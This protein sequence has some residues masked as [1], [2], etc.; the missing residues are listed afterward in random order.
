M[1]AHYTS[2]RDIMKVVRSLFLDE[3]RAEF[4]TLK[5]DRSTRRKSRL[6]EFH[7]KLRSL[8]FLDPACGCGNFLV[9]TYRELRRLELDLLRELHGGQQFTEV[10]NAIKVDVDQFYGIE[11]SEWPV[12][13]AEMALWLMDHQMN[14]EVA[15]AFGQTFRRL[16]LKNT[17]HIVQG[18]ALRIDWN[19]FLPKEQ[20]SYILGNPPFVGKQYA[21]AEQKQDMELVCGTVKGSGVLDYVTGW[22]FKAGEYVQG[23]TIIVGFVSTNSIT[24]GEQVGIL[25]NALFARYHLKIHFGHRTFAWQSEARGKA[26][27]H[28]VIIGF[29]VFDT[30]RKRLYD[31]EADGERVTVTIPN[32][33][34]PYLVNGSDV[35]VLSR[36]KPLCDVPDIVFG[37]MPNDDG[38]LLFTEEEKDELL[39][40]EPGAAKYI[41]S[42]VGSREF[43]NGE[44]R[45]CLWLKDA[46]PAELRT[47]PEVMKRVDGVRQ[48][49]EESDR[50][51]TRELAKMPTL[52]GEIRQPETE[53]LLVP[54]A[55]SENRPYIPIG[56]MSQEIIGS[57]LVLLIPRAT[58]FHFGILSSAMHM[59]WVRQICGRLKSDYRYSNRLVYNNFPWPA[60]VD[61]RRRLAVETAAQAVLDARSRFLPPKGTSTLADLYDPLS[62]PHALAQAHANL[63]RAVDRC[64]RSESFGTDR[65]R[66]EHLFAL[67]E[68]LTKPLLPMAV[69]QKRSR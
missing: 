33:I 42:F 27:V 43:I 10:G 44:G 28:V 39:K 55:S 37:N 13:I 3:L 15:E 19:T 1:G 57:N 45:W 24:Q 8:K 56:F 16:P 41:R 36:S 48:H 2:E 22:Y 69:R 26:H 67:Y 7:N 23:T 64:Y 50:E 14:V 62:M 40:N 60:E 63:D 68:R 5:A 61:E 46:S 34:S 51:T 38:H 20:C 18:N 59:A 6:D 25:W 32:N 35:V 58:R 66:V 65:E 54:S 52:F 31:Y 53:Y 12:R 9:L 4:D 17:P 29:A 11:L 47:L 49:R 30:T 21:T